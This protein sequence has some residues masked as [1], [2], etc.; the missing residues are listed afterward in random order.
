MDF[1]Q[2]VRNRRSIY[3]IG[4]ESTIGNDRIIH[5][6]QEALL[7]TPSPYNIQQGRIVLLLGGHHGRLWDIVME[8]LRAK[9][10][11]EKFSK[12]E[13]KVLSFR[14][15]Y[16]TAL[17]FNDLP[18]VQALISRFPKF[19]DT[20]PIWANHS[21]GMLQYVVWTALEEA[22]LG[23]TLQH[24]NPIIDEKVRLEW[25]IPQGW[26]LIAQM[27]FGRPYAPPGSKDYLPLETRLKV[28]SE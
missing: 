13:Q 1:L 28:F 21:Q 14:A 20:F 18:S 7:H 24:Y 6:L 27:P 12:T 9:I 17:F 15:G 8:S 22:G 26:Q 16:G 19:A 2:A 23:A 11:P 4:S 10:E 25:A 3:T 5:I